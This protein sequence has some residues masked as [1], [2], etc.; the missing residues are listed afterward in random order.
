MS[1]CGLL[2]SA[3]TRANASQHAATSLCCRHLPVVFGGVLLPP[4]DHLRSG[5]CPPSPCHLSQLSRFAPP[6]AASSFS[7]STTV[8][9]KAAGSSLVSTSSSQPALLHDNFVV[10]V[11]TGNLRG[12]GTTA[13][14]SIQLIGTHGSTQRFALGDRESELFTRGSCHSFDIPVGKEI[15]QLRRVNIE[16]CK[17]VNA[18][19]EGWYLQHV[20]VQGPSGEK[21]LFPCNAWLGQSDC[22]SYDGP[23][24]RNLLLAHHG[25]PVENPAPVS[26]AASG[27]AI[28]H[29]EKVLRSKLKG[30]NTQGYGYAGEDAYF[31]GKASSCNLFGMG[32]AD[33][34]YMWRKL[35]IDSGAMSRTLMQKCREKIASGTEDVFKVMQQSVDYVQ[36]AGL[37]GS[38][39]ACVLTVDQRTGQLHAVNLGDS[40][41]LVLGPAK[42]VEGGCS[43]EVKFRTNQLEHKFGC[44]YQIGHHA[45]SDKVED[46]DLASFHVHAGDIIVM[47]SDGLL[48]NL[49]EL[50]IMTEVML[51]RNKGL[52]AA[53]ITQRLIKL[54]F[55]ASMDRS[56]S[57][58]YSRAATQAFDMVYSGGKPDDIAVL[59]AICS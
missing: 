5:S 27:M 18:M 54:A 35:G 14:A 43:Y 39:T 34:I 48:D 44:P 57:T 6:G 9:P 29:P 41:F 31:Y 22:G 8:M 46:S 38:T 33:G 10:K 40:G 2:I 36:A 12:A 16:K 13:P 50:D 19:D 42:G 4:N 45:C 3:A 11:V 58:P 30:Y 25:K 28:P 26:I 24:E 32:V 52:T 37:Q 56:R 47:G 49:A 53:P 20:E 51:A 15:G 23:N 17:L 1:F 59:V 21:M 7:T 55:D